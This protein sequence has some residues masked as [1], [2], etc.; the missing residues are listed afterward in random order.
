MQAI[1][2]SGIQNMAMEELQCIIVNLIH[3][4]W[5]KGY[6]YF[7]KNTLVLSKTNPFP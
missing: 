1:E 3:K 2:V 6:L 5:I 7:A 4:G